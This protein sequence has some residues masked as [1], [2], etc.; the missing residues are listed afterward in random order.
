VTI[1]IL[2]A[3]PEG[4]CDEAR[5]ILKEIGE[6]V[7]EPIPQEQLADRVKG[8][9]VLIVRLGLRVTREVLE[10]AD[11]LRVVVT[12]T[13]GLDHID[14]TA[15]AERGVTVLS[16]RGDTEFLQTIPAT[17]EHTWALLLS[18]V[19]RVPWA[20]K[21]VLEGGWDR[22][23]FRGI[24]LAGRR[25]GILGLGRIGEQV[26]RYGLAFGMNVGAYDP[27]RQ[28]WVDGVKRFESLENLLRWSEILTV[29]VPL[30][31]ETRGLLDKKRLSLLPHGAVVIN[32]SRGPIIDESALVELLENGHLAGVAVDVLTDEQVP[33][34]RMR[35]PLL[36]YAMDH[37]NLLITP[38]LGGATLESMQRTEVHMAKKLKKFFESFSGL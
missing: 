35:S 31:E 30:S 23:R 28:G 26:A 11:K 29:H 13:T 17:A 25:L 5:A 22:D 33:E 4:Y 36:R 27:Y 19:R 7:E 21:S 10:A 24:E 34:R 14:L 16:L 15:A 2:N 38:H 37:E 20:F 6:V 8:F 32:T 12:A 1:R 3:E 18:L 9:H